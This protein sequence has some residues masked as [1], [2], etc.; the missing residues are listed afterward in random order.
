VKDRIAY[1]PQRLRPLGFGGGNCARD[2]TRFSHINDV[3]LKAK[4]SG[5]SW[6]FLRKQQPKD[7]V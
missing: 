5:R 7:F 6:C 3:K 4:L 1:Y 2:F